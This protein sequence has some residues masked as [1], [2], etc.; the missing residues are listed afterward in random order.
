MLNRDDLIFLDWV[1]SG[2]S[3]RWSGGSS[4]GTGLVVMGST[5][6]IRF[7]GF[8][9]WQSSQHVHFGTWHDVRV[10]DKKFRL[11]FFAFSGASASI[12]EYES[13]VDSEL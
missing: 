6:E 1:L 8:N 9:H 4:G 11:R 7:F 12:V 3:G 5:P 10:D 2:S 13:V